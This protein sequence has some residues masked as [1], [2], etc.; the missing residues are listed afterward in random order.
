MQKL[1]INGQELLVKRS[2]SE[3]PSGGTIH[4]MMDGRFAYYD[5]KTVTAR[6]HL[7]VLP[8]GHKERALAW[9]DTKDAPV[10]DE[11]EDPDDDLTSEYE[12]M[13]QQLKAAGVKIPRGT[14]K[15]QMKAL[16]EEN[17]NGGSG[18]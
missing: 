7:E 2:F 11:Q 13:R 14:N 17:F 15:E 18:M 9:F 12:Q 1:I 3:G 8:A 10:Q 5:G 4:E 6:G 16:Y